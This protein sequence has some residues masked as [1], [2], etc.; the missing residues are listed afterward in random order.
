MDVSAAFQE[1]SRIGL[2]GIGALTQGHLQISR[3]FNQFLARAGFHPLRQGSSG[4]FAFMVRMDADKTK[5]TDVRSNA[6]P[7]IGIG[8]N[9]SIG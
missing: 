5:H 7:E 6:R 3:C 1:S 9:F 2:I 4:A 8:N